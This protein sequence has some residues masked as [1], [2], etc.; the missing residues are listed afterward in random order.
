MSS[1]LRRFGR[2][3]A[4]ALRFLMALFFVSA[5]TN[6]WLAAW[7]WSDTSMILVPSRFFTSASTGLCFGSGE[8]ASFVPQISC[9]SSFRSAACAICR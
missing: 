4:L 1:A 3:S 8:L 7:I 9:A 5:A 2:G 6:K